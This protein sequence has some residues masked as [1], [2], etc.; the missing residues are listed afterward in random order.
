[1][2]AFRVLVVDDHPVNRTIGAEVFQYLGCAVTT[3]ANGYQ[4]LELM[5][6]GTFDLVCLDRNMPGLSGD[7]LV[8]QLPAH[9]FV[10]AWSTE[11]TD[12][13]ARFDSTLSKPLSVAAAANAIV[14]AVAAN[15]IPFSR[16]DRRAR[17]SAPV[18]TES[19]HR[20]CA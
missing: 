7:E 20:S 3:A 4:A 6:Q 19:L 18:Q 1:M 15:G 5:R 2:P 9:Q 14:E 8:L 12:L 17:P 11:T 10:A 16:S 13:P